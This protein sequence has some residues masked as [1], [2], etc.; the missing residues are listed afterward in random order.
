MK[1]FLQET[2]THIQTQ[3]SDFTN[4]IW[5]VPS[6]RAV[7]FIKNEFRNKATQAHIL[8]TL[9]SIEE[10]IQLL[11]GLK[12]IDA[13]KMIFEAYEAY[14]QVKSIKKKENFDSFS[15]WI[16][17]LISDLNEIDHYMIDTHSFFN[18]LK[19]IQDIDHWY[20]ATERTELIANYIN[21]WNSLPELYDILIQ[22][23]LSK[24][25]AYQ[26]LVYR[27]AAENAE[28]HLHQNQHYHYTF[29]GFNAL[30]A[31]E[32]SI[33]ECFL[34]NPHNTIYWD[35]DAYFLN[36]K[37]H[38]ASMFL[39]RYMET[40]EYF[41]KNKPLGI[42]RNFEKDKEFRLIET[43][44][45]TTQVKT[46]NTI[47]TSLSPDERRKTAIILADESLLQMVINSLP[48]CIQQVN[49]TMGA[50]IQ[51][52]PASQF[53]TRLLEIQ[54]KNQTQY[55]HK[56]IFT[57][58]QHPLVL[59]NLDG[60]DKLL[61]LLTQNNFS[62]CS[63][64]KIYE[65]YSG[66]N[67]ELLELIFTPWK[68]N[69]KLAITSCLK[70][71][72]IWLKNSAESTIERVVI[73][74]IYKLFESLKQWIGQYPHIETV[75][76][77]N[78]LFTEAIRTATIDFEG[79]AYEGLQIMGVLETRLL[80]FENIIVLSVNEGI[81]PSGK[82]NNSFISYDLKKEYGLPLYTDKDAIYTYHFYRMLQRSKKIWLCYNTNNSGIKIGEPSRFITQLQIEALPNHSIH[83]YSANPRVKGAKSETLESVP[84]N[85]Q[86][87]ERLEQIGDKGFSPST[88]IS[89][90]RN[91]LDF[92]EQRILNIDETD[93][94]EEDIAANTM[95]TIV[96]NTLEK[97]YEPYLS[98]VLSLEILNKIKKLADEYLD[99]MFQK[100]FRNGDYSQGFNLI[101]YNVAQQLIH[102]CID[103]DTEQIKQGHSIE[104]IDIE[105]S[106]EADLYVPS[107]S[108]TVKIQGKADRIE[109]FNG[110]LRIMD[111]KTGNIGSSDLSIT[112]WE[113]LNHKKEKGVAFQVLTYAWLFMQNSNFDEIEA[114][115]L[116]LR[117]MGFGFMPVKENKTKSNDGFG[118]RITKEVTQKFEQNLL[119]LIEEIFDLEM[120]FTEKE[121]K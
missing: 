111:Y 17:T 117:K 26:G 120:D 11:S 38:A 25:T 4:S 77:L 73:F 103:Y 105:R 89:Y 16:P 51:H 81:L 106:L 78:Y 30:N 46:L 116:A 50:P 74:E 39:R 48:S 98:T 119:S 43:S 23:L 86:I 9:Y 84:K 97:L 56:D 101:V 6:K 100:E 88:L 109:R 47:L 110:V 33:I 2:I 104:I 92:Y 34:Q 35:M 61:K 62:Y 37:M 28:N 32:K 41:T 49:I 108:R 118:T 113:A 94:V 12:I 112:D 85:I 55:Y 99:K 53:F 67:T 45:N 72:E 19:D 7:G 64:E 114:G 31:A 42:H 90:I 95:G 59:N 91:P 79:D 40:W 83:I 107:R 70:L 10:F 14:L 29:I 8:P 27:K 115:V 75:K 13:T 82:S 52:F 121:I 80:D 76:T 69:I 65:L 102:R 66:E 87:I 22:K 96:H 63:L 20:L 57:L 44:Q 1:T 36:N 58:L 71:C 3:Q 21:F 93:E 5:I 24:K 60:A 68:D 18:Y 15:T 54:Q